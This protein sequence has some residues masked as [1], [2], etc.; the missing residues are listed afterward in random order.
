VGSP[1][2]ATYSLNVWSYQQPPVE[3]TLTL[4]TSRYT[5][6]S[7][8][9]QPQPLVLGQ[10]FE[11]SLDVQQQQTRA[12]YS[13]T[14]PPLPFNAVDLFFSVL[15]LNQTGLTASGQFS[16]WWSTVLLLPSDIGYAFSNSCSNNWPEAGCVFSP[17]NGNALQ[18]G[19]IVYLG[20]RWDSDSSQP[21]QISALCNSPPRLRLTGQGSTGWQ[22]AV[23][24]GYS[25]LVD[26]VLPSPS[27]LPCSAS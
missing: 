20:I 23:P 21:L 18:P 6:P 7:Y 24:Q 17:N 27:L 22:G 12:Y 4:A 5:G 14:M 8:T 2:E 16:I 10:P 3:F 1:F 15:K 9:L 25:A 26:F 13:C 11:Q 19:Q